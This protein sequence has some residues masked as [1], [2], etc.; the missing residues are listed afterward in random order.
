MFFFRR[1]K[2]Q[3]T[4]DLDEEIDSLYLSP[5]DRNDPHKVQHY[6]FQRC[7]QILEA[8]KEM[9]QELSEYR[10][11]TQ[12]IN[13]ISVLDELPKSDKK[14]IAHLA[15]GIVSLEKSRA[16]MVRKSKVNIDEATY[17]IM[18]INEE[19]IPDAIRRL[20]ENETW[21]NTVKRDMQYLEAEK[22]RW[23]YLKSS[24]E[25]QQTILKYASYILIGLFAVALIFLSF[26]QFALEI[27][28]SLAWMIVTFIF[29]LAGVLIFVRMQNNS[30]EIVQAHVNANYAIT[31][32]NK[33]T[34]KYVNVKNAVDYS[35]EKFKVHNSYELNYMWEQYLLAT[36]ER[37]KLSDMDFD[38]EY[39]AGRL[40]KELKKHNIHDPQ[41]W[42][43][44]AEALVNKKEMVEVKHNWILRR[45][46]LRERVAYN[47][48]NINK[49]RAE[50]DEL[51][52]DEET[53]TDELRSIVE[54]LDKLEIARD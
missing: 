46:K 4:I 29:C 53:A 30:T 37:N 17:K 2:K 1:K 54:S 39:Y 44:Q 6:V 49:Q 25:R 43:H 50:I 27:D 24:L 7:E 40:V 42:V 41:I 31:L 8:N 45:Q 33:L 19:D 21:E 15:D 18:Q 34:F 23:N 35:C 52:Q 16:D 10:L 36:K 32:N 3:P 22:T 26:V 38:M 28:M 13:D 9:E 48:D 12:Y 51:L 47:K 5:E 14:A 11:V 20:R